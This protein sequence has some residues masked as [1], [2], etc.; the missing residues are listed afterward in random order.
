MWSTCLHFVAIYIFCNGVYRSHLQVCC[1]FSVCSPIDFSVYRDA[2]DSV[3]D[4]D[5]DAGDLPDAISFDEGE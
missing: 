4:S 5:S 2:C 3:S 1:C